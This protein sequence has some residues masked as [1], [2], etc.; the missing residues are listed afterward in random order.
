MLRPV[1]LAADVTVLPP[2]EYCLVQPP[3]EALDEVVFPAGKVESPGRA[4]RVERFDI[5]PYS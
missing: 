3:A 2:Y 4:L 5:G 1:E